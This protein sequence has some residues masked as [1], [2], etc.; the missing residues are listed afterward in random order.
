[1][2]ISQ[3]NHIFSRFLAA[4]FQT[5]FKTPPQFPNAAAHHLGLPRQCSIHP[6]LAAPLPTC[7]PPAPH[8]IESSPGWARR[9]GT[10][11]SLGTPPGPPEEVVVGGIEEGET[12]LVLGSLQ[13]TTGREAQG[14]TSPAPAKLQKTECREGAQITPAR[15]H[16]ASCI[17][18]SPAR[19]PEAERAKQKRENRT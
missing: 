1:M 13:G 6:R 11:G 16:V 4:V 12:Q 19:K 18:G 5:F 7:S 9:G 2:S 15:S 3:T 14:R 8:L 17:A 10:G